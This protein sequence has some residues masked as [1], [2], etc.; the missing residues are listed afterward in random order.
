MD[1]HKSKA[2]IRQRR[3]RDSKR[4]NEQHR[5]KERERKRIAREKIKSNGGEALRQHRMKEKERHKKYR[6]LKK[7]KK[8]EII[9]TTDQPEE[10]YNTP[11]ALGKAVKRAQDALPKSPRKKRRVLADLLRS[12][13]PKIICPRRSKITEEVS[14]KVKDFYLLDS[15]SWQAPGQKDIFIERTV[16]GKRYIPKRYMVISIREAHAIFKLQHA[17]VE[18]GLTKFSLLRPRH[19]FLMCNTPHSVCIC[20]MHENMRLRL[21]AINSVDPGISYQFREFISTIVCDQES[22]DCMSS[23]CE[24]CRDSIENIHVD[25]EDESQ[26]ISYHIWAKDTTKLPQLISKSET[27]RDILK[28]IKS[29]LKPFLLH[30]FIKRKQQEW[31]EMAKSSVDGKTVLVQVDFSENFT[32]KHQNE[33]S[34]AYWS[35]KQ[36][37]LFTS[38]AWITDNTRESIVIWS[39]NLEHTKLSI[40]VFV[41]EILNHLTSKYIDIRHVNFISDGPSSQFKQK[42]LFSNLHLWG[43]RFNISIDWNFFA[44]SHGKGVVD[45]I[46]GSTKRMI[47]NRIRS[48]RVVNTPRECF[49]V[50]FG[51]MFMYVYI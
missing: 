27:V 9:A 47:W 40:Y 24:F 48:G 41:Q 4:A 16:E 51:Y 3:Y 2:A 12:H 39:D 14:R 37:S 43:S 17:D 20:Q 46:G 31:F 38:H 10:P 7:I 8:S 6:L 22:E 32:I 30:T 36:A 11:Q 34:S 13:K 29:D 49:E 5:R 42:F 28:G 45:G 15:I 18:V 25:V 23:Q 33:I 50:S 21:K 1:G 44:T 19:V 26:E 35:H